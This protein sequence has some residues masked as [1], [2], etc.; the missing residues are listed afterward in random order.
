VIEVAN[1]Q[2]VGDALAVL[3]A[4]VATQSLSNP[5]KIRVGGLLDGFTAEL[6]ALGI[7]VAGA[8]AASAVSVSDALNGLGTQISAVSGLSAYTRGAALDKHAK[9]VAELRAHGVTTS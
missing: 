7:P 8:S 5:D 4:Q 6:R 1:V 9:L 2:S 3:R